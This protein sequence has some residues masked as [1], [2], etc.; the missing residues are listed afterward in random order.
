MKSGINLIFALLFITATATAFIPA[1]VNGHFEGRAGGNRTEVQTAAGI[2]TG[3]RAFA[4][5]LE[6]LNSTLKDP[7]ILL[8][9]FGVNLK[10]R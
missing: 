3:P 1:A 6:L 10:P 7:K 8:K 2:S 5:T 9:S 4:E